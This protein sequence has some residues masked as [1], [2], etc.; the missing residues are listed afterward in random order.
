MDDSAIVV[1]SLV[2]V[3][4]TLAIGRWLTAAKNKNSNDG[5]P[6]IPSSIPYIGLAG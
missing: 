1:T 6:Q 3:G 2:A 5:I 4:T